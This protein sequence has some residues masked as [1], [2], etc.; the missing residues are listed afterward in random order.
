MT[1]RPQAPHTAAVVPLEVGPLAARFTTQKLTRRVF[2][3]HLSAEPNPSFQ[4]VNQIL[5]EFPLKHFDLVEDPGNAEVVLYVDNGYVG[6]LDLPRLLRC[7]RAASSA[8]HLLFCESDWPFP[9]LPG[10]YPSLARSVPW[11]HSW[12]FLPGSNLKQLP[13]I[14]SED[15]TPEYLFSFLGQITNHPIRARLMQ[16]DTLSTPCMDVSQAPTRLAPFD[17]ERSYLDL[18]RRSKFVLCP[19]G[20]GASSIR[21][22]ETMAC[23]RVPVIISDNWFKGWRRPERCNWSDFSVSV[24]EHSVS[25]IPQRLRAIE[26]LAAQMGMSARRIY[27]ECFAR[28]VFLDCLLDA[29][30]RRYSDYSFST[31][32]ILVRAI[33][34]ARWRELRSVIHRVMKFGTTTLA[35]R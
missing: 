30:L 23:G 12:A 9:V 32:A 15:Q 28:N 22:F 35:V 2:V 20:W 11:A 10:A 3:H 4:A 13:Q 8:I 26:P 18:M 17:Y 14:E 25:S 29:L 6:L 7:V 1:S 31:R 5:H 33:Y 27:Q 34:T 16:L 19:R 21:I 24:P